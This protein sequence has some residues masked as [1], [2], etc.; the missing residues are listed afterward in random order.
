LICLTI[1]IYKFGKGYI[2]FLKCLHLTV[3]FAW[4]SN[5]EAHDTVLAGTRLPRPKSMPD[6]LYNLMMQCAEALPRDRPDFHQIL[7]KFRVILE[8]DG[9]VEDI[10]TEIEPYA[11]VTSSSSDD[12]SYPTYN[13]TAVPED[14]EQSPKMAHE[15]PDFEINLNL[16]DQQH[17]NLSNPI[18]PTVPNIKKREPHMHTFREM[19]LPINKSVDKGISTNTI[20]IINLPNGMMIVSIG[21]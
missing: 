4:L 18:I 12:N 2:Y 16:D 10:E 3:P 1:Q 9:F 19:G 7:Q 11:N 15:I 20:P 13:A 8:G 5:R 21:S 14:Q 6:D 17:N